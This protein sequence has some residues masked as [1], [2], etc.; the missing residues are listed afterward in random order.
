MSH[1]DGD[2]DS[3]LADGLADFLLY[4]NGQPSGWK[5]TLIVILI[6]V[7]LMLWHTFG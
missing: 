3:E 6:I 4:S 7:G 2:W 5:F 1:D